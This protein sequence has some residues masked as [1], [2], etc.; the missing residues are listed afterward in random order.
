MRK[1]NQIATTDILLFLTVW[2]YY[3]LNAKYLNFTGSTIL[4]WVFPFVLI[5]VSTLQ[6]NWHFPAPPRL[7]W[8]FTVAVIPSIFLGS[9]ITTSL[10]KYLSLVLVFYGSFIFFAQL[11][12]T[13]KLNRCLMTVVV[14]LVIYQLLNAVFVALGIGE[15][16]ERSTGITTNANTLG[17]Y[18]NLAF[19]AGF[20]LFKRAKNDAYRGLA[21]VFLLTVVYTV[22][23][24]GSRSA[25]IVLVLNIMV[26]AYMLFGKGKPIWLL[27]AGLL[28]VG[29]LVLSGKLDFLNIAAIER[30]SE[31][32]GTTREELWAHGIS[33]WKQHITVGVGYT[34]SQRFNMLT[35][36]LVFHNSYLS[37]LIEC[38]IWG[39][40]VLG[41]GFINTVV[42]IISSFVKQK[43]L[44]SNLEMI[45]VCMMIVGLAV[46]A[47]SESFLFAVG[48]TEGF[49]FWFLLAWL[50]VYIWQWNEEK[51][52]TPQP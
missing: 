51:R 41:I 35:P 11:R 48:S 10:I 5:A 36:N 42:K 13:E 23:A 34:L 25:F 30:L 19:W 27:G 39:A 26:A 28:L 9:D 45:T 1:T 37:F 20:Y 18:G 3:S 17:I 16:G 40:V 15:V 2:V 50:L 7:F 14:V 33:V 43:R 22:L 4:R 31:E 32:G 8:W 38:G 29:G 24:S 47:W 21:V 52:E 6:N 49:T 44:L 12:S 46:A